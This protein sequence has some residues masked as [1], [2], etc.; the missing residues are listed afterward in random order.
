MFGTV[1]RLKV[2][3]GREQKLME[4][5]EQWRREHTGTLEQ[6]GMIAEYIYKLEGKP[7]EFMLVVVF[8]DR[9]SYFANAN[10]P[11]T[12]RWYRQIREQLVD[13]PEW[14]DGEVIQ[15]HTY[16]SVGI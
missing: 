12:D 5:D 11:E 15:S 16:A 3:P 2:K 1:A 4:L 8:R 14:N 6:R 9:Q 7:D 13:D 10:D